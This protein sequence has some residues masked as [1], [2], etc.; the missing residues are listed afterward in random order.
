MTQMVHRQENSPVLHLEDY[1]H[2]QEESAG[3]RIKGYV[4]SGLLIVA[5]FVGGSVYWASSSKL[6]GAVVAPATF[7][8]DG[9]RKTVE[10]LEGGFVRDILVRD[11]DFVEAGEALLE[12]ESTDLDV[13]LDVLGSRL[14]DLVVRR[15][16]LLAKLKGTEVF[17]EAAV[18]ETFGT[19]LDR[20][21]WQQAYLTQLR[22]FEAEKRTRTSE[23]NLRQQRI[24][25]LEGEIAGLREQQAANTRQLD[26]TIE[27][28][29]GLETLLDRGLIQVARVNDRR[30]E[31]ERLSGLDASFRFQISQARNQIE[32]LKLTAIGEEQSRIEATSGELVT[33]ESELATLRSQFDGVKAQQRRLLVTAPVSGRVVG[34]TA[35]TNGGVVR[36]GAPIMDIVRADEALVVEARVRTVDV[37]KLFVGQQTRVR[38]SG[39]G[40][41]EVPEALGT[42]LNVSADALEDERTGQSY[43]S[44][45]IALNDAQPENVGNLKLLPGMPA[46][47][48]INTG[49]RT[50]LA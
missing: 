6:D 44:A 24:M 18:V 10:H 32:E 39:F 43:Y 47:V 28:L 23:E 17:D 42:I 13:D 49:E 35:F 22:L 26:I 41:S 40:Q 7:V 50:A 9:N 31:R 30:I 15:A 19:E 8:V 46:D 29:A 37:E 11:G 14:A 16:Y 1:H 4:F 45:K 36:P 20:F 5:M 3:A 25:S 21:V 12:L 27:E 34:M 48:L 33:I 38:L 2:I